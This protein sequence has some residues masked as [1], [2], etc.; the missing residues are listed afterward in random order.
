MFVLACRLWCRL[1]RCVPSFSDGFG[2][3]NFKEMNRE[4]AIGYCFKRMAN[5][6]VLE[7]CCFMGNHRSLSV[8]GFIYIHTLLPGLVIFEIMLGF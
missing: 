3:V 4:T 6:I 5:L 2:S 1:N 8:V 7:S